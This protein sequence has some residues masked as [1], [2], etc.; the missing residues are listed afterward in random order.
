[1]E[2]ILDRFHC[3]ILTRVKPSNKTSGNFRLKQHY[4]CSDGF[5]KQFKIF[6]IQ[7][8]PGSGRI[9]N[10]QGDSRLAPIDPIITG[11]RKGFE[12]SWIRRLHT[13]YPY[14]CNDRIDSL[15]NK[16]YFNCEFSKFISVKSSRRRSWSS[17]S[18]TNVIGASDIVN[19]LL[20]IVN[21]PFNTS[22]I[23][24]T[25]RILFPIK[26][27]TLITIRE[28]YL[29]KVFTDDVL[30]HDVLR[31][32]AHFIF[33]DLLMYKIKPFNLWKSPQNVK[34]KRK[35]MFRIK[36]VN[37][38][39][40]MIHLPKIFRDKELKSFISQCEIKEPSVVFTNTPKISSKIFNY[41]DTVNDFSDIE[42][43]V[44][45][46]NNHSEFINSDCGHVATGDISIFNNQKLRN[47]ISKGPGYREPAALDIDL[48][49]RTILDNLDL[50]IKSWSEKEKVAL[51]CFDGWKDKFKELLAGVVACLKQRYDYT[52]KVFSAFSDHSVKAELDY[53]HE[54]FVICPVDKASKNIAVI[55]KRH[56]L[57]TILNE[58]M[59][60]S[61]S[62]SYITDFNINA[63]CKIQNDFIK[64]DLNIK[65]HVSNHNSLP[66]IV[67]FPKFHKPKLS[68]RFVVSYASCTIKPVAERVNLGLKAVYSQIC[69]YSRMIFK[70]TG[71][72]R[73]W[74][75]NNNEPILEC[76]ND[77]L[78]SDR[79]RNIQTYDFSTLYTNLKHD[80]IKTAL[81]DV[82]KLAFKHS[83]CNYISIYNSGFAWVKNPRESTFRFNVDSL[84]ESID[85]IL[86]NAYFSMGN[87]IFKQI[88]GV[89]IGVNPGPFIANL[90]LF[91]YE[92]KYL[93]KLY[94]TDYFSAKRLNNTFRLIDDITTV[95]SD[96]VFQEHVNK[97]YPDSLKLNKEN[98]VDTKA[99]VLDLDISIEEGH[100]IVRVYDKRDDF[101]FKIVQYSPNCS[102]MSRDVLIGVFGSQLVRFFRICNHFN[103]F[104][105][106]V[107][108]MLNSFVNL[109]FNK[110]LLSSKYRHMSQKH[111]FKD[112]FT[113]I[114]TLDYL[115]DD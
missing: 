43:L 92:Y 22:I 12:D 45:M 55:C 32:H 3:L 105:R 106:R 47:I 20:L 111:G 7:K 8:L 16:G 68:Q 35:I 9:T 4:A 107:E 36:F 104:K 11:N 100:F 113:M 23:L 50:F 83:K 18:R 65:E 28:M 59:N 62:Y 54:N 115:L 25:K 41:N 42:N 30:K 77:Y 52:G 97:I 93:D 46:C 70:V 71:I 5:C 99:H 2:T 48:A 76:F 31:R 67:L 1:M 103:G 66:H 39:L 19:R 61:L 40:D 60:N 84:I 33:T 57:Q 21:S 75:I 49:H 81:K 102:N 17:N 27:D 63:I 29:D 101:P 96:G 98:E 79:A 72:K 64:D 15:E 91:Y 74:I 94:K 88:I 38:G 108:I 56:Y 51:V 86:D 87:M 26:R 109:G 69:S 13:Q 80:E 44:C 37:K 90:T 10:S 78:E 89:P 53:F 95:N 114:D 14:G 82:V 24:E 73:N 110:K 58:C 6:V 85:F 34:R 112:K